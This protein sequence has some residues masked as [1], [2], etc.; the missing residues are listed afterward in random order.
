[1]KTLLCDE[2][3]A[4][5]NEYVLGRLSRDIHPPYQGVTSLSNR[6]H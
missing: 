5:Q 2:V 4:G 6:L 3:F 1:M